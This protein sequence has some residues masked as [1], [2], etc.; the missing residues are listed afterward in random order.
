MEQYAQWAEYYTMYGM[1]DEENL[2]SLKQEILDVYVNEAVLNEKARELGLDAYTDE[3]LAE[4]AAKALE[5]Y[6]SEIASYIEYYGGV[7][8]T[9]EEARAAL[10]AD[11]D[12]QGYTLQMIEQDLLNTAIS[13]ALREMLTKD[14]ELSEEAL[15]EYYN[16]RVEEEQALYSENASE[17]EYAMLDG[18]P[19]AY[20][21]EGFRTVK[22]V[23]VALS[24]E[25]SEALANLENEL[26]DL[27]IALE[28][29][30]ERD[31]D[32]VS[33]KAEIE[34]EI[35]AINGSLQSRVDEVY[36]KIA[37]GADFDALIEEYG[38]DPGMTEE[39]GKS[40]GY[41]VRAESAM[42]EENFTE[43]AMALEKIGDISEPV[44]TDFGVHII[45]YTG[46]VTAG[47]VPLET[48]REALELEALAS[49]KEEAYQS[50]MLA[51]REEMG[52]EVFY[53]NMR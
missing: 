37:E 51:W 23:L 22:Q 33:R 36:A 29:Q 9:D 15:I 18:T 25:Q 28:G 53:E 19:A 26:T 3:E 16:A 6:E 45:K 52:I 12:S 13:E 50:G 48:I 7:G 17:F 2:N 31:E 30:E 10:I 38:T 39:P 27:N 5:M 35:N 44:W 47:I 49:L 41:Y 4:N 20:V 40:Q 43:A 11:M 21:P 34:A 1:G 42:W 32:D 24:D 8:I 46:D 14:V